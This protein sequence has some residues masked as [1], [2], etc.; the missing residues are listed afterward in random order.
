MPVKPVNEYLNGINLKITQQ[1]V[2]K[3]GES[4][5]QPPILTY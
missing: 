2:E 5:L 4:I 3:E 1:M